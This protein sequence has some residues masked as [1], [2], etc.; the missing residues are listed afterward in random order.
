MAIIATIIDQ[1]VKWI[2]SES[3]TLTD[4]QRK[5]FARWLA[6]HCKIERID[7]IND[8]EACL[9]AW[10][11]CLPIDRLIGEL[12]L[13]LTEISWWRKKSS[14]EICNVNSSSRYIR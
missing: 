10:F 9:T 1:I 4:A 14:E 8:L 6:G 2:A 13:F 7:I 11:E 3:R 5:G 12:S